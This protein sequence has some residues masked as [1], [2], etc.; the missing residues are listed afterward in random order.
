MSWLYFLGMNK[1]IDIFNAETKSTLTPMMQQY[2]AIK[3]Q[4]EDC[5]LFYRMG[6]FYELFFDDAVDAAEILDI[7][8]TKRGKHNGADIPMCGV[9]S[10]SYEFYLEKLIKS[11]R[12]VAI[13]EQ[14]E[15]PEEAKKRGYKAVV[16]RD[17]VRIV[18]PG[19][20]LEEN[21]LSARSSNYLAAINLCEGRIFTA[22][23]LS[24][25]HI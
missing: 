25:I 2:L 5:L 17:V 12:K 24:L 10:H 19:T 18:T 7:V 14:L 21:L 23:V 9:P 8:L 20:I 6:D 4:Y 11:G 13:C 3:S 1:Q 15:R 22:L 16:K